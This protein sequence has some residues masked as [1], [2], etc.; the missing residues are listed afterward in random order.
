MSLFR[1]LLFYWLYVCPGPDVN[2]IKRVC[3]SITESFSIIQGPQTKYFKSFFVHIKMKNNIIFSI[4]SW[5][6]Y[7]PATF[8]WYIFLLFKIKEIYRETR[9]GFRLDPVLPLLKYIF[10]YYISF[11]TWFVIILFFFKY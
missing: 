10:K 7:Y 11:K 4:Y 8:F 2:C 9:A 3:D 6:H 5:S 1:I